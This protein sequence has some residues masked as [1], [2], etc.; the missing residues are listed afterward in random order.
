M[1]TNW[2]IPITDPNRRIRGP[3]ILSIRST[4]PPP[5]KAYGICDRGL[6]E[7]V[8]VDMHGSTHMVLTDDIL[9]V[10]PPNTLGLH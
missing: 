4:A 5:H 1:Y 9:V 6:G 2:D 3:E 7:L 10:I 8:D